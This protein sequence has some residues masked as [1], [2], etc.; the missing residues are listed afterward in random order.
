TAQYI[1][2][3]RVQGFEGPRVQARQFLTQ[4]CSDPRTL[5]PLNKST[6]SGP[7]V[8]RLYHRLL[9]AIFVI[10]WLSLGV[11]VDVLIGSRGLLPL[12]PF[13]AAARAHGLGVM[14]LPT[15]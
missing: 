3:A 8:A 2:I 15:I 1:S 10:A 7:A 6:L 5:G 12:E 11:Q 13:L 4:S 14:E 9:A